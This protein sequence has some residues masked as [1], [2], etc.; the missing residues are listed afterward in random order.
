[1]ITIRFEPKQPEVDHGMIYFDFE[2]DNLVSMQG[3]YQSV[4][5][6]LL[7]KEQSIKSDLL[8]YGDHS[9]SLARRIDEAFKVI[10]NQELDDNTV[11]DCW[12]DA[13]SKFY[14]DHGF[15]FASRGVNNDDLIIG[16]N[17]GM[18]EI[19]C[20][21]EGQE[22]HNFNFDIINFYNVVKEVYK[23]TFI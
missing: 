15:R 13:L 20:I 21:K 16:F 5:K 11:F 22:V 2:N 9:K 6:W 1:M 10:F 3:S 12:H 23:V 8:F 17:N 7:D 14:H 4:L 19:S 18:G